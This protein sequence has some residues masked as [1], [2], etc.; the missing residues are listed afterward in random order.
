M[1]HEKWIC[2]V[3]AVLM[4]L[5]VAM[6]AAA[7]EDKVVRIQNTRKVN[8]RDAATTNSNVIMEANPDDE[9]EYLGQSGN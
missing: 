6:C 4:V 1:R 5:C 9:F 2:G 7:A 3:L 8:I